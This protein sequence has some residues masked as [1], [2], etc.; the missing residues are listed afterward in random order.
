MTHET[1]GRTF[2]IGRKQNVA[3]IY[4]QIAEELRAQYR[5]GFTPDKETASEGYHQI[6]LSDPKDKALSIQTRDGYYTGEAK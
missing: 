6:D 4:K 2:E 1:G 5:L 3:D